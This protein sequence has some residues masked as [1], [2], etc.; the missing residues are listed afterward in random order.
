QSL[1]PTVGMSHIV[2]DGYF[3]EVMLPH[4]LRRQ[5]ENVAARSRRK[6][7]WRRAREHDARLKRFGV[8]KHSRAAP[9]LA[10]EVREQ[11]GHDS[12]LREG[13]KALLE[14]VSGL[15]RKPIDS[16]GSCIPDRCLSALGAQPDW[17]GV[18]T[19][20]GAVLFPSRPRTSTRLS[21]SRRTGI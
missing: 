8:R 9:A 10:G 14:T 21:A 15:R 18:A 1:N 17:S 7:A 4:V 16:R 19:P 6:G 12:Q 2:D 5:L 13:H 11:A 20:T 3:A